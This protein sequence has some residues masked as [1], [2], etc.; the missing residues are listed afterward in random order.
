VSYGALLAALAHS[1]LADDLT[2]GNTT[3]LTTPQ[4]TATAKNGTSGNIT[5]EQ[6][7]NITISTPG[8]AVTAIPLAKSR[9]FRPFVAKR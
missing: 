9:Y 2:V 8:G 1:A 3:A 6:G 4:A 5:T 7:S